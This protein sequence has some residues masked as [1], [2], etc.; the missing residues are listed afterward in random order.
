M[1][2]LS[3]PAGAHPG[4]SWMACFAVF[5]IAVA[6]AWVP[7]AGAQ[8]PNFPPDFTIIAGAGAVMDT[9]PLSLVV[10]DSSGAGE[11]CFIAPADRDT[12]VCT[13]TTS[14]ALSVADLNVVW[15][16]IQLHGFFSLPSQFLSTTVADGT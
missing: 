4:R 9:H 14:F 11:F 2:R 5:L 3:S 10:V 16:A 7:R 1:T 15:D 6:G 8:I 12:A 13:T